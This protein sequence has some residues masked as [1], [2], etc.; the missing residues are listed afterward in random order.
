MTRSEAKF[1]RRETSEKDGQTEIPSAAVKLQ[2]LGGSC[3]R[4][5]CPVRRFPEL[6]L[7]RWSRHKHAHELSPALDGRL[8]HATICLAVCANGVHPQ[9]GLRP[10]RTLDPPHPTWCSGAPSTAI[11]AN[12]GAISP[13]SSA[14]VVA[15][16]RT[17]LSVS[18]ATGFLVPDSRGL[19]VLRP[20]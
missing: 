7:F 12:S 16:R 18:D 5:Y 10:S 19:S 2:T 15:T 20:K 11:W 9:I 8:L 1:P 6:R 3:H 13:G 4:N 17:R 14:G